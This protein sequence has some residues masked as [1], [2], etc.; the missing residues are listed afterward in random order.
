MIGVDGKKLPNVVV[1]FYG[2]SD[3]LVL[4]KTI[5]DTMGAFKVSL[6]ARITDLKMQ[7]SLVGYKNLVDKILVAGRG[8]IDL[9]NITL[10]EDERFL[11]QV[12]V[13]GNR[14]VIERKVDRTVFHV[15]RSIN[16]VGTTV[17]DILKRTPGVQVNFKEQIS[18]N[19]R[20]GVKVMIDEKPV[21]GGATDLTNVLKNISAEDVER[22][23]IISS[24]S[25]RYDASGAAGIIN[26]VLKRNKNRG[27]YFRLNAGA[28]QGEKNTS[29]L[30]MNVDQ[31][32]G[33]WGWYLSVND[34]NNNE[35]EKTLSDRSIS[36]QHISESLKQSLWDN[37]YAVRVGADY[38]IG[39]SNFSISLRTLGIKELIKQ[40]NSAK[41]FISAHTSADSI[42]L[43]DNR[44]DN[45]LKVYSGNFYY[46]LKLD[47]AG[48]QKLSVSLNSS[49]YDNG[50]DSRNFT[51]YTDNAGTVS[52]SPV[53]QLIYLPYSV[54]L[55]SIK[56]DFETELVYKI[57]MEAGIKFSRVNSSNDSRFLNSQQDGS[58]VLDNNISNEF[59]YSENISAAYI[60]LSKA[61]SPKFEIQLGLRDENTRISSKLNTADYFVANSR[62]YNNF[63]PSLLL[64]YNR[65]ENMQYFGSYSKRI[66]RP[67]YQDINPFLFQVNPYFFLKGNPDLQAELVD[68]FE[69]GSILFGKYNISFSGSLTKN[70]IGQLPVAEGLRT[71]STKANL[72]R[73]RNFNLSLSVPVSI[74]EFWTLDNY[75]NLRTVRNNILYDKV[76]INNNISFN[77]TLSNSFK[78]SER[79]KF[80]LSSSYYSKTIDGVYNT[81][82]IYWIYIG[83]QVKL[84]KQKLWTASFS[85][86]DLLKS[87]KQ[88]ITSEF[89]GQSIV[90][91]STRDSRRFSVSVSY[92]IKKGKNPKP[93]KK[94]KE[95]NGEEQERIK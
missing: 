1:R 65:S 37:T 3:T 53:S 68:Y 55:N 46:N 77:Y 28:L 17:F 18:V 25:A 14:A 66:R 90:S 44:T 47:T 64:S 87:Y 73:E 13:K 29:S 54:K 59:L 78:L 6:P 95:V 23:E 27:T 75:F 48:K 89:Q 92:S 36:A 26:I 2:I 7:A 58:F 80:E 15:S 10:V 88:K 39:K 41:I 62:A 5:S 43:S 83:G 60:T 30:G 8:F 93:V 21:D 9:G 49:L 56:S 22:I 72:Y 86:D 31:N 20:N 71:I 38:R 85:V 50:S 81:A 84:G 69:L 24:P 19:G 52:R 82:P 34:K 63:F 11:Q 42:L 74:L 61:L 35:L 45:K 91:V 16:T 94:Y 12:V 79:T 33:N 76:L 4:A 57:R 51:V 70:V 67:N 40:E 32:M